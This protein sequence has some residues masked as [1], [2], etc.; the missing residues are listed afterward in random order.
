[1]RI[2]TVIEIKRRELYSRILFATY[3]ASKGWSVVIGSKEDILSKIRLLK[4]G[5]YFFKSIQ[6]RTKNF[7]KSLKD[8]NFK[9]AALDEEGLMHYQ[10]EYYL[11]RVSGERLKE[12]SKFFCWGRKDYDLL[13]KTYPE[14]RSK[15]VVAGNTR[16]SLL[17]KN[18]RNLYEDEINKIKKIYGD[19]ILISTKFGKINF[20]PRKKYKEYIQ[21]QISA[22][23]VKTETSLKTAKK[24]KK[25]EEE[26]FKRYFELFD[27][28]GTELKNFKFGIL[29][30]PG[31]KKDAYEKI[32]LK[33]E[34][35]FLLNDKF[36]S[37]SYFSHCVANISCNCTTG[38]E[39][40]LLNNL[41][42]NYMPYS[43]ADVEYSLPKLVS[44][45]IYDQSE[46]ISFIK[47]IQFDKNEILKTLKKN[48][49]EIE[50]NISANFF[51]EE[52][53]K[54]LEHYDLGD[55]DLNDSQFH[56]IYYKIKR[57]VK[58]LLFA[59]FKLDSASKLKKQKIDNL[60]YDEIARLSEKISTALNIKNVIVKEKYPGIF[61]FK[62]K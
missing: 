9:I 53:F 54:N 14:S 17:N 37:N 47:K 56:F 39:T 51:P 49:N 36:S 28:L 22:G 20:V 6:H 12:V 38:L 50:N 62:N 34:N 27:I 15:L 58:I 11:R 40:Y 59:L 5:Y 18:F 57:Y 16:L 3:L 13:S 33:Y 1:M 21:G 10:D 60:K 35:I 61:E 44:K 48:N 43:D 45:N 7:F 32:C 23:Y 46:L 26:N 29:P 55:K 2:Y 4:K 25:H 41:S 19:F 31:E 42:I 8:L 52:V 24:A 30:H